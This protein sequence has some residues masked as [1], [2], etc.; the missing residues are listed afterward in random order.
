MKFPITIGDVGIGEANG[1]EVA[2]PMSE[3]VNPSAPQ[4]PQ[5]PL[6]SAPMAKEDIKND[7][8]KEKF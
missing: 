5:P 7:L 2:P 1:F 4:M 8:R 3:F 6:P